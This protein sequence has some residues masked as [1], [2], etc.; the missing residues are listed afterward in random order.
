MR[1]VDEIASLYTSRRYEMSD[2][3]GRMAEIQDL[4]EG[5]TKVDL[6]E[7]DEHEEPST[8]N[9]AAVGIDQNGMRIAST[10]PVL[11]AAVLGR[12][13]AA[14]RRARKAGQVGYGWVEA[15]ELDL[16]LRRRARWLLAYSSTPVTIGYE[17][18]RGIPVWTMRDPLGAVPGPTKDPDDMDV[19]W[20]AFEFTRPLW[21]IRA[22]YPDAAAVLRRERDCHPA[23]PFHLVEWVDDEQIALCVLG[24]REPGPLTTSWD[25]DASTYSGVG[26]RITASGTG[27]EGTS[28]IELL[29]R[30]PNYAGLCTA[31]CPGRIV[32]GNARGAY[33]GAASVYK[34]QARLWALEQIA[35]VR[36]I[37]PNTWAQFA[38]DQGDIEVVADG[39]TGRIGRIRGGTVQ[40]VTD[41]PTYMADRARDYLERVMRVEGGVP[42]EYGGESATNVR[43]GRRGESILSSVIDFV[44]DEA[45]ALFEQS[46]K[47]EMTR[48]IAVAKGYARSRQVSIHVGWK[49]QKGQVTY[50][51]SKEDLFPDDGASLSVSYPLRGA[52]AN[53]QLIRLQAQVGGGIMSKRTAAERSP[54]IDDAE[55]EHDQVIV[56]RLEEA[57]LAFVEG[58]AAQGMIAPPD[59]KAMRDAIAAD[60]GSIIDALAKAH[61]KAQE[62]QAPAVE[63]VDPNSPEAQA[64]MAVPGAGAEAGTMVPGPAP[65]QQNLAAMFSSLRRPFMTIPAERGA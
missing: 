30:T 10:F 38:D 15:N 6:P 22:N 53:A 57:A 56:E 51:L 8:P 64:G 9:I 45:Q 54:D 42:A 61:E 33:D 27:W 25:F 17:R 49:G 1:D 4:Y 26:K 63:P 55:A 19:P 18:R 34:A 5:R 32:L 48:A 43:T 40:A 41:S 24:R 12:G 16:K 44:I 60:K 35:I 62:R 20:A 37:F 50:Q 11:K 29:E 7:L 58:Q 13:D 47:H 65:D 28:R 31:V 36:G 2:H 14:V 3:F 59:I 23:T 52:D 21:W 39:M 46:L